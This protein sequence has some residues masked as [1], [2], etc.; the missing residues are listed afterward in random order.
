MIMTEYGIFCCRIMYKKLF[1][2]RSSIVYDELCDIC[3]IL[4]D[5]VDICCNMS[6]KKEALYLLMLY[7]FYM[8]ILSHSL[9]QPLI[10]L[11]YLHRYQ[12]SFLNFLLQSNEKH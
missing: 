5:T 9:N 4:T 10:F 3:L 6:L 2:C 12:P 8:L 1:S 11:F 7:R